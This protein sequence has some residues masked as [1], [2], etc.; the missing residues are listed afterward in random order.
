MKKT[1][2]PSKKAA[3]T[4]EAHFKHEGAIMATGQ[5]FYLLAGGLLLACVTG[6][7]LHSSRGVLSWPDTLWVM[8]VFLM[9][10]GLYAVVGYGLRSFAPWSRYGAGGLALLC[11][12]SVIIN[13]EIHHPVIFSVAVIQKFAMPIGIIIT[14]YA[15]YLTLF[16]KGAKVLS[17]EYR[18]VISATP[19]THYAFSKVFLVAGIILV[20]VQSLKVLTVF[21][22]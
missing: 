9:L 17:P 13:P 15:A 18:Q 8:G 21:V 2:D 19:E 1:S 10:A 3:F 12:S 14:L 22:A 5:L 7:L 20:T 4:R 6:S 11:L 16:G